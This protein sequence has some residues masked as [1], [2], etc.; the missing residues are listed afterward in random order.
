MGQTER[1]AA[2]VSFQSERI[3]VSSSSRAVS[4]VR[5]SFERWAET[6]VAS[7]C[8]TH[9]NSF[10]SELFSSPPFS[11]FL[12][13]VD[14]A[15]CRTTKPLGS[16]SQPCTFVYTRALD[17]SFPGL[18]Q[19]AAGERVSTSLP[20]STITRVCTQDVVSP[21]PRTTGN[22]RETLQEPASDWTRQK[23][24]R[25]TISVGG[26]L[27]VYTQCDRNRKCR[28]S[29]GT[30]ISLGKDLVCAGLFSIGNRPMFGF[31]RARLCPN[32]Y[33]EES[34]AKVRRKFGRCAWVNAAA[35]S[36]HSH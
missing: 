15:R 32:V 16:R 36:E 8:V 34:S 20:L 6:K 11:Q 17:R 1:L 29:P 23:G 2:F 18:R 24:I 26:R 10:Q 13:V 5:S 25:K 31:V 33:G 9:Y 22:N 7:V 30:R 12:F 3:R 14:T 35:V 27:C 4:G 21:T 28:E 19:R